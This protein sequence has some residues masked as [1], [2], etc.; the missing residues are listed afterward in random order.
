MNELSKIP[1]KLEGYFMN[2][3]YKNIKLNKKIY[4]L[5]WQS[6]LRQNYSK[7][8]RLWL[9]NDRSNTLSLFK[10]YIFFLKCFWLSI[11]H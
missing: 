3:K 8:P 2:C 4:W 1:V 5:L 10:V 9:K 7:N 11:L 6:F